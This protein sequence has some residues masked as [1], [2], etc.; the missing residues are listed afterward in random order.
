M[1]GFEC[2]HASYRVVY[3]K[4][5]IVKKLGLRAESKII[6]DEQSR[7]M[8]IIAH[9]TFGFGHSFNQAGTEI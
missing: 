3:F 6:V 5:Y 1:L 2:T 9:L 8:T 7:G 4:L